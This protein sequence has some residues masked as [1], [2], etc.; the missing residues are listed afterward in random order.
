[1]TTDHSDRLEGMARLGVDEYAGAIAP[2]ASSVDRRRESAIMR[3]L[4]LGL[5]GVVRSP[6]SPGAAYCPVGGYS[7]TLISSP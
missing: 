4:V 5:R 6:A 7:Q 2:L 3:R 1:M